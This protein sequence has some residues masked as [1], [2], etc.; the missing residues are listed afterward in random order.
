MLEHPERSRLWLESW[1]GLPYPEPY[2][3]RTIAG[4]QRDA[5]D[6][7]TVELDQS[8][9]GHKY[10]H[11]RSWVYCVGVITTLQRRSPRRQR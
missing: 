8:A 5:W 11:K 9:W 6:G 1:L 2:R 4:P 7:F 3:Q 10:S